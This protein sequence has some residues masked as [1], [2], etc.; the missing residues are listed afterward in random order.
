MAGS[1]RLICASAKL[2]DSG[3]AVRFEVEYLGETTPAF[4]IRFDGAVFGYLNRC[5]HRPME[6]DWRA[7]EVFDL[8][9]RNLI[10]STHGA[11]Y[12]PVT[13]RCLGGPCGGT[14]LLKLL[15][16]ERGGTVYYL[17]PEDD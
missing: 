4:V 10:C 16:A 1:E 5:G 6:L 2:S 3:K 7:S 12:A 8:E 17:G 13:G 15:I 14:P 11:S 9:G